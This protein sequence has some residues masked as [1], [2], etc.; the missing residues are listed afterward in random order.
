MCDRLAQKT[1]YHVC[2][3]CRKQKH[4]QRIRWQHEI[5]VEA[6][7]LK[8]FLTQS[9]FIA[10]DLLAIHRQKRHL[11]NESFNFQHTG[12]EPYLQRILNIEHVQLGTTKHRPAKSFGLSYDNLLTTTTAWLLASRNK[13]SLFSFSTS[14]MCLDGVND[15]W[16]PTN[17]KSVGN[18]MGNRR[19]E[20]SEKQA[21]ILV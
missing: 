6:C 8:S 14:V 11:M 20:T 5:S 16:P 3:T 4:K 9:T 13:M 1:T 18:P 10:T 19:G 7:A 2:V 21:K 15:R 12:L 17:G